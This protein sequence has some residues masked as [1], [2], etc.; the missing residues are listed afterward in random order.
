MPQPLTV[1][2]RYPPNQSNSTSFSLVT[3]PLKKKKM[4]LATNPVFKAFLAGTFSGTC[5]T[6]LFQ[7]LD[8]VK[9][10]LQQTGSAKSNSMITVVRNVL[11][12]DR[13]IGLWRGIA[14]SI[15]K[16]VP[17]VGLYFVSTLRDCSN[18]AIANVE[19]HHLN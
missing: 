3:D 2:L 16:T 14:P 5:S 7:P 11:Q 19:C 15:A 8:L 12:T 4:D 6:V 1:V 18:D 17:G 13:V 10:R 9:T